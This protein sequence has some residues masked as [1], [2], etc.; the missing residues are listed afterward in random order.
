MSELAKSFEPAA[1]EAKWGP[2]WEERGYAK[3]G[4]RGTGKAQVGDARVLK[5]CVEA[6]RQ[7]P[8]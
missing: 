1:I 6:A 3:A 8:G 2:L 4:Y 7:F 5:D